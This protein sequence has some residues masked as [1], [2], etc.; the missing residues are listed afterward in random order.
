MN[1]LKNLCNDICYTITASFFLS[2]IGSGI[3][4]G[5]LDLFEIEKSYGDCYFVVLLSVFLMKIVHLCVDN[6]WLKE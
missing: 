5:I 3:L 6:S 2:F 1:K 4:M